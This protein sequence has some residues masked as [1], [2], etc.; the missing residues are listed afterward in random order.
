MNDGLLVDFL[1]EDD[2]ED[3]IKNFDKV[4]RKWLAQDGLFSVNTGHSIRTKNPHSRRT[5]KAKQ[6]KKRTS[7]KDVIEDP[8]EDLIS[9]ILKDSRFD[10]DIDDI[11]VESPNHEPR[12]GSKNKNKNLRRKKNK[13]IDLDRQTFE[14]IARDETFLFNF[15]LNELSLESPPK[16]GGK[17]PKTKSSGKSRNKSKNAPQTANSCN[18]DENVVEVTE[19][20]V[21]VEI[22]N[23]SNKKK[24][25]ESKKGGKKKYPVPSKASTKNQS[26]EA[27]K[28]QDV[29]SKETSDSSDRPTKS[30]K[31]KVKKPKPKPK[32]KREK[33]T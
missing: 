23:K 13:T 32:Q 14:S 24:S 25:T 16:A 12:S 4:Q 2:F 22:E 33:E 1:L 26:P 31:A 28:K 3:D 11:Q 18:S 21:K 27:D 9:L 10:L 20:S 15:A 6:R 8:M 7:P 29:Q 5:L 30:A 19:T 17:G